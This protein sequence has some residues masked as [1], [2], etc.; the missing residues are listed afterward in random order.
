MN[1][2]RHCFV[3][4]CEQ[5]ERKVSLPNINGIENADQTDIKRQDSLFF[6]PNSNEFAREK[7]YWKDG[8]KGSDESS[9][10]DATSDKKQP[11][12]SVKQQE[13]GGILIEPGQIPSGI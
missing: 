13:D 5:I 4:P 3:F 2:I 9:A 1:G 6:K 7:N 12:F 10:F 11:N 8:W